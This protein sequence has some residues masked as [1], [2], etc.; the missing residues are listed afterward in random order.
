[1]LIGRPGGQG[2]AS[3]RS[4]DWRQEDKG[5]VERRREGGGEVRKRRRRRAG[6]S[7]Y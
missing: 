4:Q 3:G 6:E 7:I 2:E 1:M 5:E